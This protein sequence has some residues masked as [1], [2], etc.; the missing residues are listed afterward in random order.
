MRRHLSARRQVNC[1]TRV[2]E[3]KR[4]S[5]TPVVTSRRDLSSERVLMRD[6]PV[7]VSH[8]KHS[9]VPG[10]KVISVCSAS[11][12]V[13]RI[14]NGLL[15]ISVISNNCLL[16]VCF[17][18]PSCDQWLLWQLRS[19]QIDLLARSRFN[20]LV[21]FSGYLS[22]LVS[23][24]TVSLVT[25]QSSGE[26]VFIKHLKRLQIVL[27]FVYVSACLLGCSIQCIFV[28]NNYLSYQVLTK[29]QLYLPKELRTPAF[30]VCFRYVDIMNLT[31]YSE[32][33][34][35]SMPKILDDETVRSIQSNVRIKTI[36]DLTPG[37]SSHS[38]INDTKK[39]IR[40]CSV[41]SPQG[42]LINFINGTKCSESIFDIQRFSIQEYLCYKHTLRKEYLLLGRKNNSAEE[43]TSNEDPDNGLKYNFR[44]LALSTIFPSVFYTIQLSLREGYFDR[45]DRMRTVIHSAGDLPF[46]SLSLSPVLYRKA[47]ALDPENVKRYL[48][49][50][51]E[52]NTSRERQISYELR[53]MFNNIAGRFARI[54]IRRLPA[55]YTSNCRPRYLRNACV[56]NCTFES[57]VKRIKKIPFQNLFI[58]QGLKKYGSMKLVSNVDVKS[59]DTNSLMKRIL[60]ACQKQCTADSCFTDYTITSPDTTLTNEEQFISFEIGCANEPFIAN[61]AVPS[62]T[63]N[64]YLLQFLSLIGFWL[65]LSVREIDLLSYLQRCVSLKH[66][67]TRKTND[68]VTATS[69]LVKSKGESVYCL[70]T[71]SIFALTIERQ[72]VDSLAGVT[73]GALNFYRNIAH[74]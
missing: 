29:L 61:T 45:A 21:I 69:N 1:V 64:D 28:T 58:E 49:S 72:F 31:R 26:Q 38:T 46:V 8:V 47:L 42:Y 65:G 12:D 52:E 22:A 20:Q 68:K 66:S 60:A 25:M 51:K 30:T 62:V 18:S 35:V 2:D 63:F 3:I 48:E 10:K 5:C 9:R 34:N 33:Y 43:S 74:N 11:R 32:L 73:N 16:C 6:A 27:S 7:C 55:P 54:Q 53:D 71:R 37:G 19:T 57:T 24:S 39:M 15:I 4:H 59:N 23:E 70:K 17:V 40:S 67:L 41:R 44:R 13:T 50:V 14:I 56:S 36:F